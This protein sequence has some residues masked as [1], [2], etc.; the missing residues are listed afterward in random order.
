MKNYKKKQLFSSYGRF[1]I[2]QPF[3]ENKSVLDIGCIGDD[4][5][6]EMDKD[7]WLH[8]LIKNNSRSILGVDI[9]KDSIDL[10][11]G[12]GYNV[13]VADA[14]NFNLNQ[15]FDV[16]LFGNTLHCLSNYQSF[17]DSKHLHENGM[18]ILTIPNAYFF[19]EILLLIKRGYPSC[20]KPS[21]C[22]FDELS[23]KQLCERHN[24]FVENFIYI[25]DPPLK[26]F[27]YKCIQA[28]MPFKLKHNV[29]I[30]VAKLK[31]TD[32]HGD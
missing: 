15:K 5:D 25:T 28:F 13:C 10:L 3:I 27:A 24:F 32:D 31:K 11:K 17:F 8:K 18:L 19:N 4:F 9:A 14:E 7:C 2:I 1:R 29:I 12:K 22:L 21:I 20:Y 23:I 30:I 6:N 26:N 16:I